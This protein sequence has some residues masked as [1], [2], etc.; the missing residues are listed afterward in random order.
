MIG[1][2]RTLCAHRLIRPGTG[3]IRELAKSADP[4][5]HNL[6]TCAQPALTGAFHD[7]GGKVIIFRARDIQCANLYISAVA[8]GIGGVL[9]GDLEP[10][11][12]V[13][14]IDRRINNNLTI[15]PADRITG[16]LIVDAYSRV[17]QRSDTDRAIQRTL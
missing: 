7:D 5:R 3:L 13:G 2:P 8:R 11:T 12:G 10:L 14:A 6:R 9:Q 17:R 4:V 16:T 15:M 1:P